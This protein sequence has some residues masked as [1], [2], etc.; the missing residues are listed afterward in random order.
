MT[1]M[2]YQPYL[3]STTN[4]VATLMEYLVFLVWMSG[5]YL[6]YSNVKICAVRA[7][8]YEGLRIRENRNT[9]NSGCAGT[10][11]AGYGRRDKLLRF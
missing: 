9:W 10:R 1:Q 7:M 8:T 4:N 6:G 11:D 5:E 3:D 2:R